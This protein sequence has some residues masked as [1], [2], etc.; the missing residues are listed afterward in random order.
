MSTKGKAAFVRNVP[1][2]NG[3]ARLYHV[4]PPM[5]FFDGSENDGLTTDFVIVS[6]V[7]VPLSGPETYIFPANKFGEVLT[8]LEQDG[9]FRG[10]MNH[11]RALKNAGYRIVKE[12]SNV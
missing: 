10:A 2:W 1:G 9:S 6:A 4:H 12:E 11:E 3:V 8:M 7:N 5:P